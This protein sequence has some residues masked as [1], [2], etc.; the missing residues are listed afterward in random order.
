MRHTKNLVEA[1]MPLAK[2]KKALIMLHGRGASAEDILSLRANLPV[3]DFYVVAPQA[4]NCT[5]YPFSFMA[6][7]VQNEP[8]LSSA[9]EIVKS[10]VADINNA[11]IA[12]ENIFLMGFSQGACLTLEFAAR[13][14]QKWGGVI[15]LT[16][17]LIGEKIYVAHYTGNFAGTK[18]LMTN[19]QSDPHVPLA[20]SE[21]SKKQLEKLGANVLL[22][23]YPNRP[24]TILME[25]LEKSEALIRGNN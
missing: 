14:A 19:S 20:R 15:A 13:H 3:N 17:G 11:G 8:W 16:G 6:P 23:I 22:E 21:G 7:I 10:I 25:E 4:T 18:I 24:H 2:A 12:S 9:L 5:W 1:G